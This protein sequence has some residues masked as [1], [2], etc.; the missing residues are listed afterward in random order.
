MSVNDLVLAT[1]IQF[2]DDVDVGINTVIETDD[3]QSWAR[4]AFLCGVAKGERLLPD[5]ESIKEY[6]CVIRMVGLDESQQLNGQFRGK[7][8]P[9]NVLSFSYD[10]LKSY[11]GDIIICLPVVEREALEQSKKITAHLAH[12][13]VHGVLHLL[14][15]DHEQN[16]E[17]E[18]MEATEQHILAKIG[19]DNPYQPI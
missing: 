4:T 12:M 7:D 3:L 13:V 6:E 9:T 17:A 5:L 14:G 2:A 8:K 15:Y 19:I 18:V 1:D 16:D 11:L 10:D